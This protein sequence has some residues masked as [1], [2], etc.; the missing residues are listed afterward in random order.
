M[1]A[2]ISAGWLAFA[3]AV[4]PQPAVAE[5]STESKARG[6]LW[7]ATKWTDLDGK[8][9]TA[10]ELEGRVVLLDFWATW[11]APCLAELPNLRQLA[12]RHPSDD[13]VI[14][15]ITLDT[16]D[17]RRLRSFLR[18]HDITWPQVHQPQGVDGEI[19]RRF[20]VEAV[21]STFLVDR[22]GRLVARDLHGR[23]LEVTV[24]TL[25]GR[26]TVDR[27]RAGFG[28][29]SYARVAEA[30]G[31]SAIRSKNPRHRSTTQS[32]SSITRP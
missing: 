7:S 31:V 29:V 28:E 19:A 3:L 30:S 6:S 18:R 27:S 9:W 15:G 24:D 2:L 20:N 5:K 10:D 23:A 32:G 16:L 11:C 13:L 17:R 14:L 1:G 21:P 26:R 12:K 8:V 22:A 4:I 25:V